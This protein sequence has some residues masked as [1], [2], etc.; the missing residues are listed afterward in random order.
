[1]AFKESVLDSI[2]RKIDSLLN[3]K[4]EKVVIR[5]LLALGMALIAAS[6]G[7]S[8]AGKAEIKTDVMSLVLDLSTG[9]SLVF[10]IMGGI[11]VAT[12]IMLYWK[13]MTVKTGSE[14][15]G[16][17]GLVGSDIYGV[18]DYLI[19]KAFEREHRYLAESD[20]IRFML[21]MKDPLFVMADY[22]KARSHVQVHEGEF[23]LLNAKRLG[24]ISIVSIC[25]YVAGALLALLMLQVA[26]FA[27]RKGI[28]G[29]DVYCS[30]G[31][32]GASFAMVSFF[33]LRTYGETAA[34]RR[35]VES[36]K[37][38]PLLAPLEASE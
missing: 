1:M 22:K 27:F 13:T 26:L 35:L 6:Y 28:V 18:H 25:F 31:L 7:M 36:E 29:L 34:A 15:S 4:F 3:P 12:A 20:V 2:A 30:L 37:R 5:S 8:V 17:E 10:L 16:F 21:G 14:S 38:A 33:S 9:P 23:K 24:L 32:V 11:S 19:Q